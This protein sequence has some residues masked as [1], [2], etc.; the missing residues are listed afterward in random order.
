M[1]AWLTWIIVTNVVRVWQMLGPVL[2]IQNMV[3]H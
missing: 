2:T 1:T 3:C